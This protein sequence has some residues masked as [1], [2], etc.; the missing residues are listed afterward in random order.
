[1]TINE[2]FAKLAVGFTGIDGGNPN[3]PAWF[4]GIEWGGKTPPDID[5]PKFTFTI[6]GGEN[7]P[8]WRAEYRK[9]FPKCI[10]NQIDQK[11]AKILLHIF[12]AQVDCSDYRVYMERFL[13]TSSGHSFRLNLYPLNVTNTDDECWTKPYYEL[14]GFPTK[15]LYRAWCT[16]NRFPVLLGLVRKYNPKVIVGIGLKSRRDFILAY[17]D[18]S[19]IFIEPK[20]KIPLPE[21]SLNLEHI[22][23]NDGKTHLLIVPFFGKGRSCINSDKQLFYLANIIKE[24]L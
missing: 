16:E 3:G 21:S 23:T 9:D 6:S 18:P 5:N 2:R 14:T 17:A 8:C 13:Y 11:V 1:M 24:M 22:I 15:A 19:D 20:N 7:I 4:S 10:Q 12:S